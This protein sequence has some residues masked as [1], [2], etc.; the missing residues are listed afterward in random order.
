MPMMRDI[1]CSPPWAYAVQAGN[2][3]M[4]LAEVFDW[5]LPLPAPSFIPFCQTP[6]PPCSSWPVSCSSIPHLPPAPLPVPPLL[7]C[8]FSTIISRTKWGPFAGEYC[9]EPWS[10]GVLDG[11]ISSLIIR[12][13]QKPHGKELGSHR[14]THFM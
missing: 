6:Q 3:V 7:F 2:R 10:L 12:G 1:V 13:L 4:A 5:N 14:A 11:I 9:W 8:D